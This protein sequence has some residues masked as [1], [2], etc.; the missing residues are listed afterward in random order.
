[1]APGSDALSRILP[2]PDLRGGSIVNGRDDGNLWTTEIQCVLVGEDGETLYLSHECRFESVAFGPEPPAEGETLIKRRQPFSFLT[3]TRNGRFFH[4]PQPDTLF[5]ESLTRGTR[6]IDVDGGFVFRPHSQ[7]DWASRVSCSWGEGEEVSFSQL[8]ADLHRKAVPVRDLFVRA[9]FG[10]SGRQW[11]LYCPCRYLNFPGP[12]LPGGPYLQPISGHVL[13]PVEDSFSAGYLVAGTDGDRVRMELA[14]PCYRDAA[15][16]LGRS[17]ALG[18]EESALMGRMAQLFP[19]H[20]GVYDL[21]FPV[22]GDVA[23]YRQKG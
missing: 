4:I 1:M 18:P 16:V 13:V 8:S 21:V 2:C 3:F 23:F 17:L 12:R 20:V 7:E 11:S 22:D 15:E 5:G 10:L 6:R 9:R 19:A 14:M